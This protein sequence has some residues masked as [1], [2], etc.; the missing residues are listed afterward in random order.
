MAGRS[1]VDG[2]SLPPSAK[3]RTAVG[4]PDAFRQ[5]RV[6]LL[7]RPHGRTSPTKHRVASQ[8]IPP[9]GSWGGSRPCPTDERH[10]PSVRSGPERVDVRSPG[11][12]GRGDG[13]GANPLHNSGSVR[14]CPFA[15]GYAAHPACSLAAS[16]GSHPRRQPGGGLP[17]LVGLDACR[18]GARRH[19]PAVP[20]RASDAHGTT[21]H[22]IAHAAALEPGYA[23]PLT[24]SATT[25][26]AVISRAVNSA[27]RGK[28]MLDN[29]IEHVPYY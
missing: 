20:D 16:R 6:R 1:T 26:P 3:V 24:S 8:C 18:P 5:Q 10:R 22:P 28:L 11:P 19:W 21:G 17:A 27:L 12:C 9:S 2:T 13:A 4:Q 29:L 23:G 15:P 14:V 25:S 7:W